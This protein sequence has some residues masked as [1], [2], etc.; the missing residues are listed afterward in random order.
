MGQELLVLGTQKLTELRDKIDC[1][2]DTQTVGD[3]SANPLIPSYVR[4]KVRK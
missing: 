1:F 2:E 4:A 3:F